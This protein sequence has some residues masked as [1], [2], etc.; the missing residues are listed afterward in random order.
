MRGLLVSIVIFASIQSAHA[1]PSYARQTGEDCAACH[2]GSF[3]PQLTP[4]G[5]RFK[6]EG[7]VDNDGNSGK[8]PISGMVVG[9]FSHTHKGQDPAPDRSKSNNNASLQEASL[10]LAGGLTEHVGS[11]IQATYSDMDRKLVF[12]HMDVRYA[13]TSQM[14][15][16]DVLFG[17]S[18]NNLP[19]IQDPFSTLPAWGFPFVSPDLAPAPAG[20]VLLGSGFDHQA[21]GATLYGVWDNPGC[22]LD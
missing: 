10:F 8:V 11:F 1:L 19:T 5:I 4:H 12:D 17:V 13:K 15:D 16:T 7:Y 2:L 14:G 6:L 18:V 3:G 22:R 9:T 20:S 21:I